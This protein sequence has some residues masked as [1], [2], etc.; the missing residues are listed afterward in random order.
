MAIGSQHSNALAVGLPDSFVSSDVHFAFQHSA[1]ASAYWKTILSR[2]AQSFCRLLQTGLEDDGLVLGM[3][4]PH[5]QYQPR[6][7]S[8]FSSLWGDFEWCYQPF[9]DVTLVET[10]KKKVVSKQGTAV[11]EPSLELASSVV[12]WVAFPSLLHSG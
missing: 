11:A 5:A 7:P 2:K 4:W 1:T 10:G 3:G 12:W 8:P 6:N 9:D